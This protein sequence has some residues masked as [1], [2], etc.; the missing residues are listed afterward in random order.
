MDHLIYT[1]MSGASAA[2]AAPERAR[3]QPGERV[4]AGLSRRAVDLSRGAA[5]RRRRQHPGVRAGGHVGP[6]RQA[7]RD[8]AHRPRARHGGAGQQLVRGAGPRRHRGLHPRRRVPGLARR[9]AGH[10][11]RPDGAVRRRRADR[12]AARRRADGRQR[13]HRQRQ[14]RRRAL[15]H[16]RAASS[17]PRPRPTTRCGAARTACFAPPRRTRCRPTP[18]RGWTPARWKAPTSTRSRPWSA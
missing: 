13:R 3:Q 12:R 17:W 16:A 9:H 1:A 8:P 5:A 2:A 15:L 7:G 10:Q 18:R 11:Q 4:D 6:R 14:D